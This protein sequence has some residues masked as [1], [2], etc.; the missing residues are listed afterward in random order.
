MSTLKALW[1]FLNGKKA[2]FAHAYWAIV[3]PGAPIRW[4]AGIPITAGKVI[5]IVGMA[6]TTFGY[7]HKVVK[8]IKG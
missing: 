4:P 6:L 8:K 5:A 7:T 1:K 2:H 3:V